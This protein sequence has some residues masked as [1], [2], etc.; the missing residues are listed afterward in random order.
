MKFNFFSSQP[1]QFE[2]FSKSS[3]WL[4]KA[5]PPKKP[6]LFSLCE[7]ANSLHYKFKNFKE[8]FILNI[9]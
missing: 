5:G 7:Q 3:D 1:E 8:E 6:L 9:L 2:K 4:E